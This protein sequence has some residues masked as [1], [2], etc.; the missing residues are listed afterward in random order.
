MKTIFLLDY[1]IDNDNKNQFQKL[2]VTL[3]LVDVTF[4][5]CMG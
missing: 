2:V 4:L 1:F 5:C 3:L